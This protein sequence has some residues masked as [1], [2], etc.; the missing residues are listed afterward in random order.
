MTAPSYP[1]VVV[2]SYYGALDPNG[3]TPSTTAFQNAINDARSRWTQG[4]YTPTVNVPAGQY[5]V[6]ALDASSST[7]V[8]GICFQGDG[9][10]STNICGI[11]TGA[12]PIIDFTGVSRPAVKGMTIQTRG[13]N[14]GLATCGVLFASNTQNAANF[15]P[16]I[17][18]AIVSI[19]M[20][21]AICGVAIGTADGAVL[22]DATVNSYN[23]AGN[24]IGV[25][26]G[27]LPAGI[28]SKFQTIG[29]QSGNTYVNIHG[30]NITGNLP[31]D[32]SQTQALTISGMT[33]VG[34]G[35][36]GNLLHPANCAIRVNAS[37]GCFTLDANVRI[38]NQANHTFTTFYPIYVAGNNGQPVQ[39]N[40]RGSSLNTG[41]VPNGA[42]VKVDNGRSDTALDLDFWFSSPQLP[43]FNVTGNLGRVSGKSTCTVDPILTGTLGQFNHWSGHDFSAFVAAHGGKM[44]TS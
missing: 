13:S 19:G 27:A 40:V 30:S 9:W 12:Y 38:E 36:Y 4:W 24:A 8:P 17:E 39:I 5:V 11:L 20:G 32:C 33:Y 18:D 42:Y 10:N 6:D 41:I 1:S 25:S 7:T 28:V 34:A 15:A 23:A 21:N 16:V 43:L 35:N 3:V 14:P 2:S 22:R 31:V 44:G 29:A 37:G 26:I